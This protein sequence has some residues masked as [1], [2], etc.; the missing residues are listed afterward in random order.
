MNKAIGYLS[1]D[2][3]A[4]GPSPLSNSM[5]SL[6][7]VLLTEQGIE[8]DSFE[9][10]LVRRAG[11]KEDDDTM[12]WWS[13][14]PEAWAH[15]H[16]NTTSPQEG[17]KQLAD[18]YAKH[19]GTYKLKWVAMPAS[20]DWMFMK[21]Y[22]STFAPEDSVDIGFKAICM[23]TYRDC[24]MTCGKLTWEQFNVLFEQSG[25]N[26]GHRAVDD[27]RFQGKTFIKLTQL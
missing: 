10:N 20:F 17:M 23:S 19:S 13:N 8:V 1:F 9:V 15:C 27:A 14:H 16:Q 5:L 21:S 2:V 26:S 12:E 11:S 18:F 7:V 6:G 22:Y 24:L 3:E 4:D 25:A